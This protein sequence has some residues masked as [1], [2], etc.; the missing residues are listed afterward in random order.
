MSEPTMNEQAMCEPTPFQ[1]AAQ[2]VADGADAHGEAAGLV[3]LMTDE[4]RRWCLDGDLP[5]WA[6]LG[7]LGTGGYHRRTFPA[8]RV[9]RL[10]LGG[11]A[12]SDG[13]R[14]V[15][16]GPA[17]AFP[18]SMARGATWDPDLEERIGEAIGVELRAVGASLYGGVC[19]N[20]LRHPAWGRAQETYGEDPFHV[21]E[22]GAALT[23]GVQRHAMACV[24]HFAVNSMENARFSVDVTVDEAA[25]H[26]VF[27]PQFRR[28][29]DE[30]V[31]VVMSAYNAL[32]GEWCGQHRGLLTDVLRAEWGFDGFVISDWIFGLR[33]AG[34]SVAAGLDVE[35]PYRMIRAHGLEDALAAG[36]CTDDDI[37]AAATRTVA[38]L[39]RFAGLAN[40]ERPSTDVLA[41][42]EHR[43][44]ARE[45]ATASIVLL[46]NEPVEGRPVL[47]VAPASLRRVAVLGRLADARNLG[48]GGSSDVWA[49]EVVTPLAGLRAALGDAVAIDHHDGA[50]PAAAAE[51]ARGADV[52]LVVVGYT[53]A[54]EGEFIGG[55]G[56]SHL[57][58]HMP[59]PDDPELAAAF[60]VVLDADTDPYQPPDADRDQ[61]AGLGFATGGDRSSLR[62][63]ASDEALVTAVAAITPRTVVA[64]VA[65]SAVVTTPWDH[66]VPAVVQAWYSGMEGGH[67]LADVL[68]GRAEPTGRLP[69]TVPTEP[70]HLPPFDRDATEATYDAWHGYWRLARDGQAAAFPF[71]FGLSYT[72]LIIESAGVELDGHE[73]AVAATVANVGDRPGVE[74]VQVYAGADGTPAR[75]VGFGRAPLAAGERTAVD[76]RIPLDRLARRDPASHTWVA[77]SGAHRVVVGRHAEDPAAHAITINLT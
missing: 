15:V 58:E 54:D 56:I 19:V 66:A 41:C 43:A 2:R 23:R 40:A 67:T 32:N 30:G 69:F 5:F 18:V 64:M 6:G 10:G 62:L 44:L 8:A 1:Q 42:A 48:D 46:R 28:I 31:A 27:L 60:Q 75:L 51:V 68:L 16:I 77:P 11:F 63:L 33:D 14:G 17:T 61:P 38:T 29:V 76:V 36:E 9:D 50:D 70:G 20:V 73:I 57:A 74:V 53:S 24:K 3:A 4:E 34:P 45:A 26:E 7:D 65:G 39:L 22:M 35:M 52:A 49:P 71:G 47:P 25:L 59:G 55:E 37:T 21:G 72:E 13:P 12:F